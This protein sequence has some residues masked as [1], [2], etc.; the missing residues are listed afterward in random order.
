MTVEF[1]NNNPADPGSHKVPEIANLNQENAAEVPGKPR[2]F[3]QW[4][5]GTRLP[6]I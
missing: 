6:Q 4:D 3:G 5:I 2:G 1:N